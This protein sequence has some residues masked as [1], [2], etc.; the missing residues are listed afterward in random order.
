MKVYVCY[1]RDHSRF[2]TL[3]HVYASESHAKKWVRDMKEK[4]GIDYADY[5][6]KTVLDSYAFDDRRSVLI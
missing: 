3:Y 5:V 4:N 1:T 2:F 6:T